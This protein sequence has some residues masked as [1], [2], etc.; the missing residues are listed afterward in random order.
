MKGWFYLSDRRRCKLW[1]VR[2]PYDGYNRCNSW[3]FF[4]AIAAIRASVAI[5]AIIWKP[6]FKLPVS[7]RQVADIMYQP[8]NNKT[9][10]APAETP[11][12]LSFFKGFGQ[13]SWYVGGLDGQI[14]HRLALD[15]V[16]NHFISDY[17]WSK[18]FPMRQ[19]VYSNLNF[20]LNTTEISQV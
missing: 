19:T 6:G 9:A 5:V 14:P 17:S 12:N 10:H 18:I 16:S 7:L 20:H 11:R 4:L 1:K 15:K 8:G 13:I 2:F 3:T